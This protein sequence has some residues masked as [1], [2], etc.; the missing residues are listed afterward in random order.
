[1]IRIIE[2]RS[3]VHTLATRLA[4]P[5]IGFTSR[6]AG[7]CVFRRFSA[8]VALGSVI[9]VHISVGMQPLAAVMTTRHVV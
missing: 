3:R 6:V 5:V 7:Q 1:V 2:W 9:L 8:A 4:R